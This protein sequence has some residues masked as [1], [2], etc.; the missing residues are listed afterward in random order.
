MKSIKKKKD[1]FSFWGK[2]SGGIDIL[3]IQHK[4]HLQGRIHNEK[5]ILSYLIYVQL[6]N[7]IIVDESVQLK[8]QSYLQFLRFSI[9]IFCDFGQKHEMMTHYEKKEKVNRIKYHH[10]EEKLWKYVENWIKKSNK[11]NFIEDFNRSQY[12]CKNVKTFFDYIFVHSIR[13]I[14]NIIF[15]G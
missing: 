10:L 9:E 5:L 12:F 1:W 3:S 15:S 13:N 2:I 6:I 14:E 8:S 11:K 7:Q 4:N